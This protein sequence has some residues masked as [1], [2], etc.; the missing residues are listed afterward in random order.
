M[1]SSRPRR[2]IKA[3]DV[4][5]GIREQLQQRNILNKRVLTIEDAAF[6]TGLSV[7]TLYKYTSQGIIPCSKPNGKKLFFLKAELE[8]WMLENRG[9]TINDTDVDL[10]NLSLRRRGRR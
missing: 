6:L 7:N 9:A 3:I 10:E 2:P 5:I 4:L 1:N 8:D